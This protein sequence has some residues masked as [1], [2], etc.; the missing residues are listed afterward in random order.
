MKKKGFL[1]GAIILTLSALISKFLGAV[2]RIP[3][4]NLLGTEGVGIYQMIF[5]VYSLFLVMAGSGVPVAISKFVSEQVALKNYYNVGKILRSAIGLMLFV[6]IIFTV[7]IFFSSE[8]IARL[9]GNELATI[10]YLAVAPAVLVS[11]LAAAFKGYF[12][13]LQNMKP[14]AISEIIEQLVR[15]CSGLFLANLLL[16]RGIEYGV[17]GAVLGVTIAEGVSLLAIIIIYFFSNKKDKLIKTSENY[18]ITSNKEKIYT[19][20]WAICK[21]IIKKAIP[22]TIGA[23]ILPITFVV[24]SILIINLLSNAGF[25][26]S[27]ATSLFGI[28]TGVVNS[29][30]SL[31]MVI[32]ISMA[33]AILPSITAANILKKTNEVVEK[34]VLSLKIVWLIA[35][36]CFIGLLILAPDITTFLYNGGLSSGQINE[37][38][39]ASSLIRIGAI[40]VVYISLLR[41]FISILHALDKS[42]VSARNLTIA[43]LVKIV[44][45]LMLV[46]TQE[47]NIYGAAIASA[48]SYS[49]A[50]L[51]SLKTVKKSIDLKFDVKEFIVGPLIATVVMATVIMVSKIIIINFA[52]N[53]LT[54]LASIILGGLSYAISLILLNVFNDK[55]V[56]HIKTIKKIKDRLSFKKN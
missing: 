35:L 9:Q 53:N 54:T 5:P 56:S 32:A 41:M 36:P 28:Q 37:M 39:V 50:C 7:I 42:Y 12:Q 30:I 31:P 18:E 48:F 25:D 55:E 44:I 15:V 38:Q 19:S 29:L 33:T 20:Y 47:I 14:T 43:S 8:F 1:Y 17:L 3:L 21:L 6:G 45:T 46:S 16:P 13:G 23:I 34:S 4:T 10:G 11:S 22:V 27:I 40:S 26:L 49:I 24:D 2:Y 52:S 51:L